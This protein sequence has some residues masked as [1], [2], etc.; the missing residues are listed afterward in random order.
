M[1]HNC[2]L[3]DLALTN[4]RNLA[5]LDLNFD[6]LR[7]LILGNNGAGKT[8]ILES[9]SLLTPGRG[10]RGA[11]L[12][13]ICATGASGFEVSAVLSGALGPSRLNISFQKESAKRLVEFNNSKI[14]TTELANIANVVW[15]TPQM[16]WLFLGPAS[17]RR[18]Y[19]DRVVFAFDPLHASRI[20]K[21]EYYLKERIKILELPHIDYNWLGV[22]ESKLAEVALQIIHKRL[23]VIELLQQTLDSLVSPFP[24]ARIKIT[25]DYRGK[26]LEWMKSQFVASRAEDIRNGRSNFGPHR[27]DF[28]VY[29]D[30]KNIEARFCSTGEQKA[31]LIS[32]TISQ[33]IALEDYSNASP[34]LLLDE[35]FVHL[36]DMRRDY[37]A[38]FL[39]SRSSQC[40][41]TSTEDDLVKYFENMQVIR[42]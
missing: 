27:V 1:N 40:L 30:T 24:K 36:D 2:F 34:I 17:D 39:S 11:K 18:R 25:P 22:I 4:Y 23:E 21:Y 28:V 32:L 41:I 29:Y 5:Q 42:L 6:S 31:M 12:D 8:N 38:S 9:I 33:V 3:K 13:E 15:L 35:I 7:V 37:L 26:D 14:T 20:N 10:M 16:E 19:F